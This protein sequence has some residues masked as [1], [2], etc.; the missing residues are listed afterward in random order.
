MR[1]AIVT[2][3]AC[4]AIFGGIV[5]AQSANPAV[6]TWKLNTAKSKYTAGTPAKSATTKIEAAGAGVKM[7]VD[8]VGADGATR[9]WTFATNY[10]GK[11]SPITGNS[12]YGDTAAVTRDAST[13]KTTYKNAGKATAT[14]TSVVSADGKMRTVTTKG[15]DGKGQPVDSVVIYDRQ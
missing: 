9:H 15:T 11:D 10:D 4:V 7:T 12:Q 13:T 5:L 3:A 6:G 1:N 2:T 8:S 14:Q